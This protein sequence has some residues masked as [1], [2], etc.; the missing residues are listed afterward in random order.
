MPHFIIK[1]P[2]NIREIT[3]LCIINHKKNNN[4]KINIHLLD[5][6][7]MPI[8]LITTL[9]NIYCHINLCT[10]CNKVCCNFSI[11]QGGIIPCGFFFFFFQRAVYYF[12]HLKK[13]L[14]NLI[15]TKTQTNWKLYTFGEKLCFD[16]LSQ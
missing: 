1:R 6:W 7:G 3:N 5:S 2:K 15:Q 11:I 8:T 4:N 16:T 13:G 9:Y 10:L 12:S 14:Q